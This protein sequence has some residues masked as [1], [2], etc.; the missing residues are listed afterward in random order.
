MITGQWRGMLRIF[1]WSFDLVFSRRT[2]ESASA[3]GVGVS[4]IEPCVSWRSGAALQVCVSTA[5]D[6]EGLPDLR[7]QEELLLKS[8]TSL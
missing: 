4:T 7:G 8:T 2:S 5:V 6:V 1:G 3:K